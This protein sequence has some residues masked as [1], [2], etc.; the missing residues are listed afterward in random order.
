MK[1]KGLSKNDV[2]SFIDLNRNLATKAIL[3]SKSQQPLVIL[4]AFLG[5]KNKQFIQYASG[6]D[7]KC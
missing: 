4:C 5:T 7:C 2:I 6:K 3:L 1:L